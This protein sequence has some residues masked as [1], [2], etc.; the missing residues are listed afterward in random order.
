VGLRRR[1]AGEGLDE[2]QRGARWPTT[3]IEAT[4]EVA[5][6]ALRAIA[7]QLPSGVRGDEVHGRD[8]L[9]SYL[10]VERTDDRGQNTSAFP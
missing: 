10:V 6:Q 2:R 8:L 9:A 7:T 1:A 5:A 3:A 4:D